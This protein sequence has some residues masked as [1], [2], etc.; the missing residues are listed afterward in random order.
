MEEKKL[1]KNSFS[2]DKD[3]PIKA[4]GAF[5]YMYRCQVKGNHGKVP[6]LFFHNSTNKPQIDAL[7]QERLE[8]FVQQR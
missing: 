1:E 2:L 7:L 8:R 6:E 4:L 3:D 5:R